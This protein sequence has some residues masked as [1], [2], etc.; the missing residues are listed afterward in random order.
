MYV[1][2]SAIRVFLKI[3]DLSLKCG[4][5]IIKTAA[6]G[7]AGSHKLLIEVLY[8]RIF[9]AAICHIIVALHEHLIEF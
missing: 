6:D 8:N 4:Y 5:H 9:G 7:M 1:R 2:S 3:L